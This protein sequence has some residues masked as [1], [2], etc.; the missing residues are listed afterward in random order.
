MRFLFKLIQFVVRTASLESP[1]NWDHLLADLS[2]Q[3]PHLIPDDEFLRWT[4]YVG[5]HASR[6]NQPHPWHR[7]Q[8]AEELGVCVA[9]GFLAGEEQPTNASAMHVK[10]K[11]TKYLCIAKLV[12]IF[13]I[14]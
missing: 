11:L 10:H 3:A 8:P 12:R 4:N 9:E 1:E 5:L 14:S 7:Y 6:L 2:L 13:S